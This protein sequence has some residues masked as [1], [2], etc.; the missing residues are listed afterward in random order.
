M[1]VIIDV[2][3]LL[4]ATYCLYNINILQNLYPTAKPFQNMISMYSMHLGIKRKAI[5]YID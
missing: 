4:Y 5:I 1:N 2:D 3:M